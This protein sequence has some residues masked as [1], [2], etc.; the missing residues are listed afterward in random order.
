LTHRASWLARPPALAEVFLT[1]GHRRIER[2]EPV[3][4]VM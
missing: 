3:S 2:V 4:L 1:S